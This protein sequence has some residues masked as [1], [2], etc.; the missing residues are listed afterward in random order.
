MKK[1]HDAL[2]KTHNI[3]GPKS[4]GATRRKHLLTDKYA[5]L[6][7][8]TENFN[9]VFN[10][11]SSINEDAIYRLSQVE[12][13]VLLDEFTTVMETRNALQ[14]LSSGKSSGRCN[15]CRGLQ[16]RGLPMT[17]KLTKW[18]HCMW[19]K[20]AIPKEFKDAFIIHPYKRKGNP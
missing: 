16:G 1:L 19:R 3:Y 7:S 14:Q 11:P 8:W 10:R 4:S 20:E 5:I 18:F 13:N 2:E 12:F 17:E 6:E 9:R 15:S